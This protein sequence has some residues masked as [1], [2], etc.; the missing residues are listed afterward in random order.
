MCGIAG[1]VIDGGAAMPGS[2]VLEAMTATMAC[3]GPDAAGTWMSAWAGIGH[4]RLAVIDVAGGAQPM[5][6]RRGDADVVLTFSGEIYNFRELRQ[7]LEGHG[8][9][10][11]T[12]SDTEVLLHSY[13]QWGAD[14]VR[15]LNGMFAFAIWD[16]GR[17]TLLLA[18]DRLGVK[19]LF[20]ARRGGILLFGSEIKAILA[21]PEIQ[22]ELGAGGLAE[23]FAQAGTRTPG[24]TVY[25]GINEV[26]PGWM[27]LA[28]PDRVHTSPYWCLEARPHPDDVTTTVAT[29]RELLTDIVDRQLVSDVPVSS[30]LSG[31][32]DSSVLTALA[33]R[34]MGR[35]T[36][37]SIA[38][39][40]VDF[41]GSQASFTPDRLRPSHDEPY[42][43]RVAE[44]LG[45]RHDTV[46]LQ[47]SDLLEVR[48]MPLRAHDLPAVG[49]LYLSMYLLF[50]ALRQRAT[51]AL[52][53]ESADEVFGGYPWY[54]DP[55]MLAAPTYP[56][57]ARGSWAPLLR[58]D[59]L[60]AVRLEERSRQGYADALREVPVLDGE[61]GRDRRIR[62]VLHL[63]L[64]RWLPL[65]LERKD[66]LSM[67][68]GLEVRVPFCDHRLV[69]Y[70]WNVPWALK[71]SGGM[72]K[73]LLRSAASD[74]LP[75]D[76]LRR[77]KSIYPATTDP[78]YE[79]AVRADLAHLLGTV[80]APLFRLLDR[81]RLRRA[82]ET[83]PTLPGLMAVQ[84][85][86][87]APASFLL[88]LDEWLRTYDVR[89][90][91]QG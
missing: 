73:G 85:S 31:G 75:E 3:R 77:R 11:D 18:R 83:D 35:R 78:V 5:R 91:E 81:A 39:A 17:R 66:R 74:L 49:D 82:F 37:E 48:A 52:S 20:Y 60:A 80:D 14:C 58:P 61:E 64:T 15:R 87:M 45:T 24:R 68:V 90:V 16:E 2:E 41:R 23:L 43:R 10:F 69:Q 30:L 28:T 57:A 53:G 34:S 70:V 51:V 4:R 63:G 25:R 84:P 62:E 44:H 8:H 47:A 55:S 26:R 67:A 56:W 33:Q 76:V 1:W 50:R 42:A 86:P 32:L 27:V 22:A 29:V 40:S 21:H 71:E 19:P 54:H 38:T 65:L 72:E 88:D 46:E 13:L 9:N 89:L 59:V 6:I 12:R 36:G 79:R 7:E